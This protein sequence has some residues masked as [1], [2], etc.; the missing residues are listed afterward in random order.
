M[1]TN[2]GSDFITRSRHRETIEPQPQNLATLDGR[3]SHVNGSYWSDSY[4]G[5]VYVR[6]RM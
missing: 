1:I 6:T 2:E 5:K 4:S 3:T